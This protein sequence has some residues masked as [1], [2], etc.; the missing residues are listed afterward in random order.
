MANEGSLVSELFWLSQ[1]QLDRIKRYFPRARGMPR[2]DDLRVISGIIY[3]I[4]NGLQWKDAPHEY[5]PYKILYY[6][7]LPWSRRGVFNHIFAELAADGIT[8]D[9]LTTIEATDFKVGAERVGG[10]A[11]IKLSTRER[12]VARLLV[13]GISN[14]EIAGALGI[15]VVTVKMHVGNIVRKLGARN[16]TQ[17]ALCLA[18]AAGKRK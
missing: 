11:L 7:F 1:A 15:K 4:R 10:E 2:V 18:E 16:R 17:A 9:W 13:K 14:K 8:V 12:A 5:G 3:V 6:R